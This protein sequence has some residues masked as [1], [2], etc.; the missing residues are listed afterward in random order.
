M[1]IR[2]FLFASAAA[3]LALNGCKSPGKKKE[4]AEKKKAKDEMIAD[5]S[6]DHSFQAF[7][8]RLRTAV[9][10]KDAGAL[11]QLMTPDFGYRWDDA[12]PGETVYSYWNANNLWPELNSIV[13]QNFLPHGGFMVSPPAFATD[14]AGFDGYRAGVKLMNGSW[15]FAYFVDAPPLGEQALA[16]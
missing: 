1:Q 6:G 16:Q 10:T 8:G 2:V 15:R 4:E 14:R 9:R 12:P 3:V 13:Q 7:L 5:Q 11:A